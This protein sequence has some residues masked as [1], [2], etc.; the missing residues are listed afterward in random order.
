MYK[1][2]A[3]CLIV[4]IVGIVLFAAS[5]KPVSSPTLTILV[6]FASTQISGIT[7][8]D[9]LSKLH[10]D[11]QAELSP[12]FVVKVQESDSSFAASYQRNTDTLRN[13]YGV[14]QA[15]QQAHEI[16][17]SLSGAGNVDEEGLKNAMS[18]YQEALSAFEQ[19]KAASNNL[20]GM[21]PGTIGLL[22]TPAEGYGGKTI[23]GEKWSV[24]YTGF[25]DIDFPPPNIVKEGQAGPIDYSQE[26][27]DIYRAT[28]DERQQKAYILQ[29]IANAAKKEIGHQFGLTDNMDDLSDAM[30]GD[31]N[32]Q[33]AEHFQRDISPV[34]F[35]PNDRNILVTG[36]GNWVGSK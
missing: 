29:Y 19:E 12:N 9:I 16:G 36:L 34:H 17:K 11:L 6:E 18:E 32:R 13:K 15:W 21:A 3:L 23:K 2:K 1:A 20:A 22:I 14:E 4:A 35:N 28:Y 10:T 24:L 27:F 25:L 7:E 8:E 33:A 30:R 5:C 31:I 26:S